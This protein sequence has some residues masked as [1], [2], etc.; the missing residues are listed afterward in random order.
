MSTSNTSH[1]FPAIGAVKSIRR[2]LFALML[3]ALPVVAMADSLWGSDSS[4]AIGLINYDNP[5]INIAE[6]TDYIGTLFEV[7]IMMC[8]A[9]AAVL[10]IVSAFII[11][12]KMNLHEG[13]ITK[14]IM[15]L[16]G[17][18]LFLISSTIVGP[19]FFGYSLSNL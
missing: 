6:L 12:V 2:A 10:S 15:Y 13:D 17:G 8:N 19:A 9:I 18:V 11:Y 4:A 3:L 16:V 1:P 14:H 7:V 5:M